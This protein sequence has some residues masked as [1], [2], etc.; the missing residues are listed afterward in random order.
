MSVLVGNAVYFSASDGS[1][2]HELWA[3]DTSNHSTWQVADI[4]NP[5]MVVSALA[6]IR[7][8]TWPFLW[9]IPFTSRPPLNSKAPNCG[10]TIP[11]TVRHGESLT[12]T[13]VPTVARPDIG[14]KSSSVIR[15]TSPQMMEA[16]ATNCGRTNHRELT[17]TPTRVGRSPHGPSTRACRA[18]FPLAPP[19]VPSTG[20]RP[21]C[22]RKHPTWFRPSTA[23]AQ[24]WRT[25]TSPWLTRSRTS[26]I[27]L[28]FC[29]SPTTPSAVTSPSHLPSRGLAKS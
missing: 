11:Q 4:N 27:R 24:A 13:A 28:M 25:S 5:P 21:S 18:V 3:H 1:T 14:W 16:P 19:T 15:C 2:G 7:E 6:V 20:R 17:T 29:T 12:S 9:A 26:P 23:V 22:G 8:T 10:R